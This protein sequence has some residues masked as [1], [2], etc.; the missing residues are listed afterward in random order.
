M[1]VHSVRDITRQWASSCTPH[2]RHGLYC[3]LDNVAA[4]SCCTARSCSSRIRCQ[5][6]G[7]E[8]APE[9]AT[10]VSSSALGLVEPD[11]SAGRGLWTSFRLGVPLKLSRW[12]TFRQFSSEGPHSSILVALVR[13]RNGELP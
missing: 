4:A 2:S 11:G 13:S 9:V 7:F 6:W 8:D 3:N 1:E 12:V 5:A 10:L